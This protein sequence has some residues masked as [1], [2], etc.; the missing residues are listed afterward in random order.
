MSENAYGSLIRRLYRDFEIGDMDLLRVVLSDAVVWHEPGR[1]PLAGDYNGPD[2]V[3]G[4]LQELKTRSD[5]TFEIEVLDVIDEP[6]RVVVFQRETADRGQ[7]RL[8][9]VAVVDFEVHHEKITEVT[10][11]HGDQYEF[12]EFWADA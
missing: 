6:E 8:D 5:G 11:Y 7:R 1:S 10:V 9:E 3:L 12:D 2:A 4:L